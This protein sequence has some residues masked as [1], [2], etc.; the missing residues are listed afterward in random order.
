[1]AKFFLP[2][3]LTST[4]Q[5][6]SLDVC[7]KYFHESIAEIREQIYHETSP[8][9]YLQA[10]QGRIGA[11]ATRFIVETHADYVII[12]TCLHAIEDAS[13]K[14]FKN[15]HCRRIIKKPAGALLGLLGSQEKTESTSLQILAMVAAEDG[16]DLVFIKL[17][18]RGELSKVKKLSRGALPEQPRLCFMTR[19]STQDSIELFSGAIDPSYFI[20]T[21]KFDSS[22]KSLYAQVV[23]KRGLA[24]DEFDGVRHLV[25]KSNGDHGCS[26]GPVFDRDWNIYGM[27][28]AKSATEYEVYIL[29]IK[30]ITNYLEKIRGELR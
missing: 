4:L 6:K 13:G 26:G 24:Q 1:M 19:Q 15:I 16:S 29:P 10:E 11:G 20:Y 22:K 5:G 28:V 23:A 7:K 12:A 27:V 14:I 30:R 8:L 21:G 17:A 2:K 18:H 3:I 25:V 9:V